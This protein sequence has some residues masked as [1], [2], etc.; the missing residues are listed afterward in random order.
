MGSPPPRVPVSS[1]P[2]SPPE[3]SKWLVLKTSTPLPKVRPA[4]VVTS[5]WPSSTLSARLTPSSPPTCGPRLSLNKTP[6]VSTPLG[7]KLTPRLSLLNNNNNNNNNNDYYSSST[8]HENKKK[9][10]T[11]F[12]SFYYFFPFYI[13]FLFQTIFLSFVY[14]NCS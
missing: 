6:L 12:S 13:K 10:E 8:R 7:S 4:L 11:I 5:S 1:P 2:P 14:M 9:K 3:S